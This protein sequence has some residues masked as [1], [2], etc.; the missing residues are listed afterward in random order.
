MSRK[1]PTLEDK[2]AR[3]KF[4]DLI[5]NDFRSKYPNLDYNQLTAQ[6]PLTHV[7]LNAKELSQIGFHPIVLSVICG[8]VFGDTSLA[9]QQK[10]TNAR[11]QCRHSTR[12]TEWFMWKTL[13]I[14]KDFSN[15][16]S[17]TFQPA[18]G[19]QLTALTQNGEILGKWHYQSLVDTKLTK[20]QAQI[21]PNN[22]KTLA[23]FW[24]NHM[25]NYFLMTLWLDDGSLSKSRQ[26]V[27]S[28]NST[29]Q[30]EAEILAEYISIVWGVK[31]SA[32]IVPSKATKTNP[33][34]MEIAIADFENLEKFIRI[35]APIVPVKSMLYKVCLYKSKNP[36]FL[37]RW[38]SDLKAIVRREW[39]D[40][41]DKHYAYLDACGLEKDDVAIFI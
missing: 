5:V 26:G 38:I 30:K 35:I 39:H 6:N 41:I 11:L 19:F 40:D 27:I 28:C 22:K 23:R 34:P 10:Y 1:K 21:C 14:L 18:D 37:K 4:V 3:K 29:P 20:L 2:E 8:T 31:C 12:Q 9:I 25:N 32:R 7:Y 33:T 16:K 17:I 24:L 15:E 36:T 13:C